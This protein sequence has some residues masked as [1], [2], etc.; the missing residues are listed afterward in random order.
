[1]SGILDNSQYGQW[2]VVDEGGKALVVFTSFIDMDFKDDSKVPDQPVEEGGFFSYNKVESPAETFVTLAM[3]GDET[4]IADAVE[5]LGKAKRETSLL[6]V[7]TPSHVIDSVTLTGFN[8]RR[9]REDGLSLLVVELH[10]QEIRQVAAQYVSIP[11]R[12][13]KNPSDASKQDRGKVQN[14]S[15]AQQGKEKV[16]SWFQ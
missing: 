7:L 11:V 13:A 4:A 2:S 8:Y 12:Q 15:I 16:A 6:S 3:Q 10:L 5:T 14:K 9:R 1:M